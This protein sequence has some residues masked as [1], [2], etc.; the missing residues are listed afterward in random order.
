M[1]TTDELRAEALSAISEASAHYAPDFA[2]KA[3]EYFV[4]GN[5]EWFRDGAF[6]PSEDDLF[7][8]V[9]SLLTNHYLDVKSPE[10]DARSNTWSS[11]RVSVRL[12]VGQAGVVVSLYLEPLTVTVY[13]AVRGE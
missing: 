10:W 7:V 8:H 4:R 1:K 5:W 11:G 3:H 13:P 6:V 2:K 9:K 12:S